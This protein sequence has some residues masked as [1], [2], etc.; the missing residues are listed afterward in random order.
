MVLLL[1]GRW[2]EAWP[3]YEAR[4]Q[5]GD[6]AVA[7]RGFPQPLWTGA[8]PIAGRTIL[9]HAEQG[10]GDTLQFCRYAPLV[11][12]QGARVVLEVQPPLVRLLARLDGRRAG[13]GARRRA[14]GF[15]PALPADEP[16]ARVRH[17]A[18]HGSRGRALP[19]R[20]P[21]AAGRVAR[22][23]GRPARAAGRPGLGRQ[24]ARLAAARRGAGS[25]PLDAPGRHGAAR[26]GSRLFVRVAAARPAGGATERAAAGTGAATMSPT[27][28]ATSPTPRR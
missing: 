10:F 5:I 23:A 12:A 1:T 4:W 26:G 24:R 27:G 8:Q 28:W 16:A 22:R 14:A 9:L 17:H 19:G 18:G 20:R 3:F 15:R 2:A 21:G 25:A 7:R 11:A 13:A 6:L